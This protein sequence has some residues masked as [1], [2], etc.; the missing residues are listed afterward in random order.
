[1][2]QFMIRQKFLRSE[3][4][5]TIRPINVKESD[6]VELLGITIDKCFDF[7]KHIENLRLNVNYKLHALR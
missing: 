4:C 1:M 2:F 3:C 6:H 7:K 5:L